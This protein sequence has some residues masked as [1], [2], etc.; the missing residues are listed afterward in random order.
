MYSLLTIAQEED[1][2]P[3]LVEDSPLMKLIKQNDI[4]SRA[5]LSIK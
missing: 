4:C 5:V 2:P 1:T 3:P